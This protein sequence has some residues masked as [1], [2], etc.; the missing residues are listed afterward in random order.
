MTDLNLKIL[1][2]DDF[3]SMRRIVITVLK[4]MG[5]NNIDEAE[6]KIEKDRIID[7]ANSQPKQQQAVLYSIISLH[8]T[9]KANI[10][11]GEVYELYKTV[12]VKT[13]MLPL[14]Q[15]RISDILAELDM[16]GIIN[17]K[18]ISKGRYGRTREISLVIPHS[19]EQKIKQVLEEGLQ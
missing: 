6:E 9:G 19:T 7:I 2:V 17:A 5:Y 15:R 12:C 18:I 14:T 4:Q 11:T 3:Q 13:G 10:F 1:V 8:A 16:L